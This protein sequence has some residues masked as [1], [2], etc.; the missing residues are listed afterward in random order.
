MRHGIVA[1][2]ALSGALM[3]QD[4]TRSYGETYR[5]KVDIAGEDR[6][7]ALFVPQGVKRNESLPLLVAIP[8]TRGKAMLEI[9]QWQQYGLE[10]RFAVFSVDIIT[11]G[12]KGW[13]PSEQLEMSRD[14]EAVTLGLQAALEKAAE[15]GVEIDTSA[16]V[17]T[18]HSGGTYLTLWLG[19]R[20]PDLFIGVCGRS[21]VF[22]KETVEFGKLDTVPRN[23]DMPIFVYRGELDHPRVS[24][25]TELAK[26]TIQ[27]AGFKRVE[28]AIIP[29]AEHAS[30]PEPF[31]EWYLKLLKSTA[32]GRAEA[33]RIRK[34][35]VKVKESIE[36]GRAGSY[37]KLAALAAKEK[38]A[39]FAAGAIEMLDEVE[40]KAR[41][42]FAEAE[43]FEADRAYEK[44]LEAFKNLEKTYQGLPISKEAR[45]R[46]SALL[47]SDEY[48]ANE[49][50]LHAKELMEKEQQE[51]GLD[52]LEKLVAKYPKTIAGA[53]A[54]EILDSR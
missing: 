12:E 20:R 33:H 47:K 36:K 26:K 44:A 6:K 49:M 8:D 39:G 34:D 11:S 2:L 30:N 22:F 41:A 27:D 4:D 50:L 23:Y 32:K 10:H 9:G 37:G 42:E 45:A 53:E 7:A 52:A 15:V 5:L 51:K 18:G 3:A 19:L 24:K 1:L 40:K 38:K 48:L 16:N 25:E 35:L 46:R 31:L 28:Y 14:M 43:N 54:K 29:K 17:I 21:C 13:H